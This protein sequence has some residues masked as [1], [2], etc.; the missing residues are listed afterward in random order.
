MEPV[1]VTFPWTP[2]LEVYCNSMVHASRFTHHYYVTADW[3]ILAHDLA[4]EGW[5]WFCT[6]FHF[7][8][9]LYWRERKLHSSWARPRPSKVTVKCQFWYVNLRSLCGLRQRW[10]TDQQGVHSPTFKNT[11]NVRKQNKMMLPTGGT[12]F[13]Q[14]PLMITGSL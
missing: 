14:Q 13:Q 6:F 7:S 12:C 8:V 2:G 5:Q 9:D 1:K 10:G 3:C 4:I 11:Q